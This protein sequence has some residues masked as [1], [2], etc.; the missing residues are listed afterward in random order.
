[1]NN[2]QPKTPFFITI[3][4]P[5]NKRFEDKASFQLLHMLCELGNLNVFMRLQGDAPMRILLD[6]INN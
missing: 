6:I 3:S 4:T 1:M 5:K 2:N